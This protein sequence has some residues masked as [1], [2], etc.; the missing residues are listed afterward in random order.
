MTHTFSRDS[1]S[2]PPIWTRRENWSAQGCTRQKCL[3]SDANFCLESFSLLVMPAMESSSFLRTAAQ[4]QIRILASVLLSRQALHRRYSNNNYSSTP[5][6]ISTS[7]R[8]S[9]QYFQDPSP[10]SIATKE[11]TPQTTSVYGT[12]Q[13]LRLHQTCS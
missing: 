3:N 4:H 2:G 7:T 6:T 5:T 11:H 1:E 12:L 13:V 9:V 8:L 10:S